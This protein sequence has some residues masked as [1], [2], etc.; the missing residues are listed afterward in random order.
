M[1]PS[2]RYHRRRSRQQGLRVGPLRE[3]Q[4]PLQSGR[5]NFQLPQGTERQAEGTSSLFPV[6]VNL[7]REPQS[8][9]GGEAEFLA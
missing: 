1:A 4:R 7:L 8:V 5:G 3:V 2:P 6:P 9:L